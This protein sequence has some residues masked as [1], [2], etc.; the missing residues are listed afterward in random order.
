MK[1]FSIVGARPQFIKLA[2][3][4]RAFINKKKFVHEIIHT[5]QHYDSELSQIFFEELDIPKPHY[6]LDISDSLTSSVEKMQEKIETVL[7]KDRPSLIIVYG[8][9]NSTLAGA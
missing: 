1:I 7:T 9:T 2:A 5:G 8:D 4:H 3:I 6:Q